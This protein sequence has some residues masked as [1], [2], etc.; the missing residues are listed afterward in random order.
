MA[1]FIV[2]REAGTGGA[3]AGG[4]VIERPG[5][6]GEGRVVPGPGS[7]LAVGHGGHAV[8]FYGDDRELADSAAQFLGEGLRAGGSAVVVA[9]AAHRLALEARLPSAASGGRL[10]AVNAGEMLHGFLAGG[11]LDGPRFREAAEGLIGRAAAKGQPVSIYAEMVALLWDAGQVTLA[12]ELEAL[13]NGLAA[14][15]PFALLCGYPARLLA[16]A[17]DEEAA[18]VQH[19]CRL[20]TAVDGPAPGADGGGA[21]RRF[22]GDLASVREARHF[23]VAALGSRAAGAGGADAAITAGEL[24]ANAVRHARSAFTVTVSCLP[25]R[26]RISVQ[27]HAPLGGVPLAV[28]PGHGLHMIA[29]VAARWAVDP[30]PGGKVVW[31]ELPAGVGYFGDA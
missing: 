30:L 26:V 13:W 7:Q 29:Q 8:Q 15:L 24:A 4:A 9:T 22:A 17:G 18:G 6:R 10:V 20:H 12:L 28:R 11:R 16:A 14:R 21:V 23:V 25:R 19:V 2:V 27:D 5:G 1:G 31:A 3:Y